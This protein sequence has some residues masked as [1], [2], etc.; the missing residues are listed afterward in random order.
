M[1]VLTNH[2]EIFGSL[3]QEIVIEEQLQK[4][5]ILNEDASHPLIQKNNDSAKR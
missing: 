4:Q 1:A 3:P 5:N 2:N